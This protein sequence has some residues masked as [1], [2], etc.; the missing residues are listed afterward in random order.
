MIMTCRETAIEFIKN[1]S[2]SKINEWT[3]LS[4]TS[5]CCLEIEVSS[6]G[7]VYEGEYPNKYD[8]QYRGSITSVYTVKSDGNGCNCDVCCMYH[9]FEEMT[10]D[11]FI[12]TYSQDDYD[13]CTGN[14]L[15]EAILDYVEC[16]TDIRDYI[17]DGIKGLEYGFFEDEK[18]N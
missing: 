9:H 16:D 14:T 4:H 2:T 10:K 1:L 18:D 12:E 17:I 3:V 15:E 5:C 7:K 8:H 13:Y 11:E 6:D